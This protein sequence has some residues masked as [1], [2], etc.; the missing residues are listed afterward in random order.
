M[1]SYRLRYS[2][3]RKSVLSPNSS[4]NAESPSAA[5]IDLDALTSATMTSED[6]AHPLEHAITSGTAGGWKAATPGV[7]VIRFTFDTPTSV[8][9]VRLVFKEEALERSQEFSLVAI[10]R[11]EARK[12]IVRQQW[13]FSPGGSTTEVEDY[14]VDLSDVSALELTI[15]PGRH[16]KAVFATLESFQVA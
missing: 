8:K 1:A 9:R 2:S 6:Q 14:T 16:D 7:Q 5:W 4:Y 11:P 3:M 12:E 15:D 10:L 13:S